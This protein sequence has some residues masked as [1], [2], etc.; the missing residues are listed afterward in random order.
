MNLEKESALLTLIF[1]DDTVQY[2]DRILPT[3]SITC[4]A[5][6][7]PKDMLEKSLPLCQRIAA[8]N[9]MLR[10]GIADKAAM[11]SA[12]MAA[13][14]LLK[15]MDQHE[16]FTFLDNP[17]LDQRLDEVFTVDAFKK[18]RAFN[19]AVQNGMMDEEAEKK[20]GPTIDLLGL[21]P[22]LANYYD[23]ISML[24]EHIA[25]FADQLDG[26][27][28]PRTKE[29]YLTQFSQSF[30]E[31]FRIGDSTDS[32]MSM[33]NVTVQYTAGAN[34]K[35]GQ[36]QMKK[37][38]HFLTFG[39]MLRADFFE[40]IAVG[41]APK[42]CAICGRWFL[43]TD[44][45]HTKYCSDLCPTDPLGRKCRV[46]GNLQGR[47]ARELAADHPLNAP[48][49]RRMNTINQCLSRG[50][51]SKELADVMKKLAKDKKQRAKADLEYSKGP[52]QREM[53]QEALKAE[54]KK[55]LA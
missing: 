12:C 33:T 21:A 18:I 31:N 30:P 36:K 9:T 49:T 35:N 37:H 43:T 25:P 6:N 40:G 22:C 8:V 48:Y 52:Y 5:M 29:A 24:Q 46:I 1:A 7:I 19:S 20:F 54:A 17:K 39:G 10:I 55:L 15:L 11:S 27:D 41:H 26:K 3:G 23:A 45:R 53:E 32:W 16:P 13:H 38:M 51:I 14:S 47:A 4:M 34:E 2:R 28:L 44:A 42:R 50:T